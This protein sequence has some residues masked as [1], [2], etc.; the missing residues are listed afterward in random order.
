MTA[1]FPKDIK[2]DLEKEIPPVRLG[3]PE[4]VAELVAFLASEEATYITG[5]VIRVNGGL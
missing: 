3:T 5:K 4:D 2:T 1:D